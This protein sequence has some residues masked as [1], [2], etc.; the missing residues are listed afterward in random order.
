[1]ERCSREC[2][3]GPSCTIWRG[4]KLA[5]AVQTTGLAV[6]IGNLIPQGIT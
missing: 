3:M 1:M 4:F 5:N 2:S 6:W